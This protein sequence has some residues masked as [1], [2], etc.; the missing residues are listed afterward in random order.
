M[1]STDTQ[2][3]VACSLAC[4]NT[5]INLF[6]NNNFCLETGSEAMEETV[7]CVH[8][9]K[10]SPPEGNCKVLAPISLATFSIKR[11]GNLKLPYPLLF[12]NIHKRTK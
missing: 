10:T 8:G 5:I 7:W 9:L 3:L 2:K 11:V 12:I 1:K 6:H 4:K